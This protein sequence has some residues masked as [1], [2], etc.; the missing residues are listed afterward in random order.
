MVKYKAYICNGYNFSSVADIVTYGYGSW[1]DGGLISTGQHFVI[2]KCE[3]KDKET[4]IENMNIHT[5]IS[6]Y[7]ES[8]YIE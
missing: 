2:L 6:A 7:I 1:R 8:I 5:G 4:L 3:D